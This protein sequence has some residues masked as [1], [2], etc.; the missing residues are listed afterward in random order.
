MTFSEPT[1]AEGKTI[2]DIESLFSWAGVAGNLRHPATP[3]GS[4]L[5]LLELTLPVADFI[6]T[7]GGTTLG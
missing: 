6:P 4:L 5:K 1:A 2:V 7:E 3:A